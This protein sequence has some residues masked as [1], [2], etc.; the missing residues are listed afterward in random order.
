MRIEPET[1]ER[2]SGVALGET[3]TVQYE[4]PGGAL[5]TKTGTLTKITGQGVAI[6]SASDTY[7]VMLSWGLVRVVSKRSA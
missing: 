3:V 1:R 7:P 2:L 5:G 6:K 4:A